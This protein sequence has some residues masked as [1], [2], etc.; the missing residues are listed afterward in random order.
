MHYLKS[1]RMKSF[2]MAGAALLIILMY[3]GAAMAVTVPTDVV[4]EPAPV[5]SHLYAKYLDLLGLPDFATPTG[6]IGGVPL[7]E[8]DVTQ[9][10]RSMSSQFA[11]PTTLWGYALPGQTPKYL[12]PT[13]AVNS[14]DPIYV[15]VT[16]KLPDQQLLIPVD[17]TVMNGTLDS[18]ADVHFHGGHVPSASDGGPLLWFGNQN[19]VLANHPQ[20][21][22][23]LPGDSYTYYYPNND[24]AAFRWYHDHVLG[25]TR[26][27]TYLGLAGGY[28]TRD[29]DEALL[30]LPSVATG[31]ET[32]WALQDRE[33]NSQ[34]QLWYPNGL[35]LIDPA[36][37]PSTSYSCVPEHF[38]N[39]II[40]NGTVWPYMNVEQDRIYRVHLLEG[41]SARAYDLYLVPE[42]A[43]NAAAQTVDL[44]Q[45]VPFYQI[46]TEQG[47]LDNAKLL[48]HVQFMPGQR[49]DTLFDFTGLA[50]G[51][52]VLVNRAPDGMGGFGDPTTAADLTTTGQILQIRVGANVSGADTFNPAWLTPG[53]PW[54]VLDPATAVKTRHIPL[55]ETTD[56]YGRLIQ[57]T[58]DM[59]GYMMSVMNTTILPVVGTTE[60]WE[61]M[62]TTMDIH[63]MHTHDEPFQILGFQALMLDGN[64]MV[65]VDAMGMPM[66][67]PNSQFIPVGSFNDP[68]LGL[69]ASLY[70]G[71]QDTVMCPPGYLTRVII[72]FRDYTGDYVTHCHILEHEEHDMMTQFTVVP[73]PSSWAL[74]VTGFIGFALPMVRR[75]V[76]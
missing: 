27:N 47:L 55:I 75:F 66:V 10:T 15:K 43:L 51:N 9:Y 46:G 6:D 68:T 35:D 37:F 34:N 59:M 76:K 11:N 17:T 31:N 58:N 25:Q 21:L 50:Q 70:E 24:P 48:N 2:V 53:N 38:G 18:L 57:F 29:A 33:F 39:T 16:N 19:Y 72:Q 3:S 12:G 44:T 13:F 67:D 54:P 7:Y 26:I 61:F 74:I 42:A 52:Y 41:S 73:E 40:V 56:E 49:L 32:V 64:G 20:A 36:T 62:N 71:E 1:L 4:F 63:P 22:G 65:M 14:G 8:L 23:G 28:I 45:A 30:N 60:I 5:D 69:Y